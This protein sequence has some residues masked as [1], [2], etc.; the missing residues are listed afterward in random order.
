M[1]PEAVRK[2]ENRQQKTPEET[3]RVCKGKLNTQTNPFR[4]YDPDCGAPLNVAKSGLM[5]PRSTPNSGGT[6]TTYADSTGRT[7]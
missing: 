6:S 5:T 7:I 3:Y 1:T 2:P 4:R